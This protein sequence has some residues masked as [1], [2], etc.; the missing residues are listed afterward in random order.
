MKFTIRA[1]REGA[2]WY[3]VVTIPQAPIADTVLTFN[4]E[5]TILCV[6]FQAALGVLDRCIACWAHLPVDATHPH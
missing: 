2:G 4:G 1:V 6:S 5:S 3:W